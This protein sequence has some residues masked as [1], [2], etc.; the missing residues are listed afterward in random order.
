MGNNLLEHLSP[1]ISLSLS[2]SL[3]FSRSFSQPSLWVFW[4][5]AAARK[6]KRKKNIWPDFSTSSCFYPSPI[7]H[8]VHPHWAMQPSSVPWL[9]LMSQLPGPEVEVEEEEAVV[10]EAIISSFCPF[11]FSFFSSLSSAAF[12]VLFFCFVR[13]F[14][15]A[16]PTEKCYWP[17]F[18]W[19]LRTRTR[20]LPQIQPHPMPTHSPHRSDNNNLVS[21]PLNHPPPTSP[22]HTHIHT[23]AKKMSK[24]SKWINFAHGCCTVGEKQRAHPNCQHRGRRWGRRRWRRWSWR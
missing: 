16:L 4:L 24:F 9:G 10:E 1:S 17:Q 12:A 7:T 8:T 5:M 20:Y 2:L 21:S 11:C 22:P 14:F 15:L 18:I 23:Q 13:V 6:Q 3:Y 19:K